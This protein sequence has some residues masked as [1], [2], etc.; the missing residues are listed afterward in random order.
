MRVFWFF[1]ALFLLFSGSI[2]ISFFDFELSTHKKEV[3]CAISGW[4]TI[5][6]TKSPTSHGVRWRREIFS[7]FGY[8]CHYPQKLE[9]GELETSLQ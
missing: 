4:L 6:L 9:F 1:I 7:Y 8:V 2:K 3:R 5:L